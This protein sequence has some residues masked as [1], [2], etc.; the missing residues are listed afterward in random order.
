MHRSLYTH[1]LEWLIW[2]RWVYKL[3]YILIMEYYCWLMMQ[4]VSTC[5]LYAIW[6]FWLSYNPSF[7]SPFLRV[8]GLFF[9]LSFWLLRTYFRGINHFSSFSG[10]SW[11][12][13]FLF[14]SVCITISPPPLSDWS[15]ITNIIW[16]S[17]PRSRVSCFKIIFKIYVELIF[18]L[19]CEASVHL[20]S[21]HLFLMDVFIPT[22][23]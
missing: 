18:V 12:Y 13:Q 19:I 9:L 6:L 21:F 17:A 23:I 3:Q 15:K 14:V 4:C 20:L 22:F 16:F 2:R 1:I 5:L 10:I 8:G 11:L 7:C